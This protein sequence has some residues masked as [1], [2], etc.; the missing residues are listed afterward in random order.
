MQEQSELLV[1]LVEGVDEGLQ[2]GEVT[3]QLVDPQDPHDSHQPDYLASLPYDLVV[4][5]LLQHQGQI[6]RNQR[7]EVD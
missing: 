3:E 4:L 2:S 5:Q 7:N 1:G 6:E